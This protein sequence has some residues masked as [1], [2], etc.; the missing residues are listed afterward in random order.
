MPNMRPGTAE[1]QGESC[2][3]RPRVHNESHQ[4]R[5]RRAR[6]PG[7]VVAAAQADETERVWTPGTAGRGVADSVNRSGR[8]R[9]SSGTYGSEGQGLESLR[10]RP[11]QKAPAIIARAF[12]YVASSPSVISSWP[13]TVYQTKRPW[14]GARLADRA[15]SGGLAIPSPRGPQHSPARIP[16]SNPLAVRADEGSEA[17]PRA[18]GFRV[19]GNGLLQAV[20]FGQ[21]EGV[22]SGD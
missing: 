7:A 19:A 18:C 2:Q 8:R 22:A 4:L 13:V 17:S 11:A 14:D 16:L 15:R 1:S 10:V 5:Q 9:T 3:G 12:C 21:L 6:L 20:M